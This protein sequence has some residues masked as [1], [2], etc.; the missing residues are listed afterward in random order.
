MKRFSVILYCI[1]EYIFLTPISKWWDTLWHK[2]IF[3]STQ[4]FLLACVENMLLEGLLSCTWYFCETLTIINFSHVKNFTKIQ[5]RTD[6]SRFLKA[7][8]ETLLADYLVIA[9][10][11][12]ARAL[13]EESNIFQQKIFQNNKII[14][15]C[16]EKYHSEN[17]RV[18]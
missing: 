6:A 15:A 17:P 16:S 18:S 5:V 3:S 14:L 2:V 11:E 8:Y 9:P 1:Y 12:K 7:L 10:F 13:T 4:E